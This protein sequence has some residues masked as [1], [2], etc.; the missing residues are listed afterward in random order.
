M[1]ARWLDAWQELVGTLVRNPLR[2]GLTAAGVAWGMFM[3]VLMTFCSF[4]EICSSGNEEIPSKL[5]VA[6]SYCS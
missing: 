3:L 6:L 5:F 2:T 4:N 1:V